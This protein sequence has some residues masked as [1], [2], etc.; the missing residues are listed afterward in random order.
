MYIHMGFPGGGSGKEST[1]NAGDT[2]LIP[3]SER[4]PGGG[5]RNP[6]QFS[7]LETPWIE[8]PGAVQSIGLQRVRHD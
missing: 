4:S 7:C 1:C 3:G 6:L 2:G 8:E 5:F